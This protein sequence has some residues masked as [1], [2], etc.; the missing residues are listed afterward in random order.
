MRLSKH[1]DSLLAETE[2]RPFRAY[3]KHSLADFSSPPL[4][5]IYIFYALHQIISIREIVN[6]T[7]HYFIPLNPLTCLVLKVN[8]GRTANWHSTGVQQSSVQ[9]CWIV[10]H[11][12]WYLLKVAAAECTVL[13]GSS[14]ER[15]MARKSS[16]ATRDGQRLLSLRGD[17][18]ASI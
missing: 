4:I 8:F 5:S 14:E 7:F 13:P 16:S 17:I 2:K 3:L 9:R 1:R 15:T 11:H 18:T 12:P 10:L 6:K